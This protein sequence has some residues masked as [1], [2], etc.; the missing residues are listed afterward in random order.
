[1]LARAIVVRRVT[2]R[3]ARALQA[4]RLALLALL[5]HRQGPPWQAVAPTAQAGPT[6]L[7]ARAVV[8]VVRQVTTR[9]AQ[10]PQ[11]A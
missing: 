7:Q 8:Q 6:Q 2:I 9:A 3:Q 5:S 11:H 4:A 10:A 1:M